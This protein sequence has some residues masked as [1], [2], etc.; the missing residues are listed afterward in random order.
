MATGDVL[1]GDKV[2][3]WIEAAGT[4]GT[5][6]ANEFQ[7]EVT[8]FDVSGGE[9]D[10]DSEPVFSG[11]IDLKKPQSQIEVTMDVILRFGANV[12]KWDALK[13]SGVA[14]MIAIESRDGGTEYYWNAFNNVRTVNFDKEFAAD[15]EWRGTMTFKLSPK[16]AN[17]NTNEQVTTSN[18]AGAEDG[19]DGIVAWS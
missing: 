12:T 18:T 1:S 2:K 13:T 15:G 17:G 10:Y 14:K 6:L 19:T 16:D 4:I 9:T 5:G 7:A 3:I 8:S 11:F